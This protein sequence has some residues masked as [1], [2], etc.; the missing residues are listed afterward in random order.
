VTAGKI[1]KRIY[2][3]AKRSSVKWYAKSLKNSFIMKVS[4]NRKV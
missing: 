1:E 4:S 2:R 3:Q